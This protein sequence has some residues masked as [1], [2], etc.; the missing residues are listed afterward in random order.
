MSW[1]DLIDKNGTAVIPDGVEEIHIGAFTGMSGLKS[2]SIPESVGKMERGPFMECYGLESITV[3]PSNAN[4]KSSG[5]CLLSKDGT[6]LIAG[7]RNSVIPDGVKVIGKC[8]FR[9]CQALERINIP[10]T[11]TEICDD[12]FHYCRS[13]RSITIPD[14][15]K[16][17]GHSAFLYCYNIEEIRTGNPEIVKGTGATNAKIV[18]C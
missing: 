3:D 17:I 6:V 13:L 12:A 15:V 9:G 1:Y 18:K 7:C 16:S 8:A 4:Y 11:V 14:S 2:I 10:D 5:N